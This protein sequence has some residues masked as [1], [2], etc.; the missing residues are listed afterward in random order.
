MTFV[1]QL[2]KIGNETSGDVIITEMGNNFAP[3]FDADTICGTMNFSLPYIDSSNEKY[4]NDN[5]A[6]HFKT[7]K[8]YA[9][10]Q[11][12]YKKFEAD[13]GNVSI[14]ELDLVFTG[15]INKT[16]Q[17]KSKS[18]AELNFECIGV[19]GISSET[20]LP[21]NVEVVTGTNYLK[22]LFAKSGL[23]TL[24]PDSDIIDYL[25]T[26]SRELTI[27]W[28]GEPN[29]KKI[30]E[31][32]NENYGIKVHQRGDGKVMIFDMLGI[33]LSELTSWELKLGDSIFEIDY[34][35]VA[36]RINRIVVYGFGGNV[37]MAMDPTVL[38]ESGVDFE[39]FTTFSGLTSR[40]SDIRTPM[41]EY[42]S[43]NQTSTEG[44]IDYSPYFATEIHYR[45]DISDVLELEAIA[46]NLL[47]SKLQNNV[48]TIKTLW[49]PE[50]AINQ[51]VYVTDGEKY[52]NTK[53]IIK[54]ISMS[55]SKT[56]AEATLTCFRSALALA[57]ENMVK[58]IGGFTDLRTL[59][60]NKEVQDTESWN[61]F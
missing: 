54:K 36:S 50:M 48:V 55:L 12:Y 31:G 34:G 15:Y 23:S 59:E 35:D 4:F 1:K 46:R 28:G 9:P 52:D 5:N 3:E 24:I 7:L 17:S 14:H 26:E 43:Q 33:F 27:K 51:V 10:I 39:G 61:N 37:G 45:Q 6:V 16:P 19:L 2:L 41:F 49:E 53:F 32:L 60:V 30:L 18:S 58:D 22:T 11:L 57:P 40:S 13:P 47:F 44:E 21:T 20:N 42:L 25:T 29:I 56:S 8:R 38:V